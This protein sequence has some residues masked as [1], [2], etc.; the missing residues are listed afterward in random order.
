MEKINWYQEELN[1]F[2]GD[3]NNGY[4]YG[5]DTKEDIVWYKTKEE[6]DKVLKKER[7]NGN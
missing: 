4:V 3:N 2:Y 1:K 6:R 7:N 5:I